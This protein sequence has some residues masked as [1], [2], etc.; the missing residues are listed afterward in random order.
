MYKRQPCDSVLGSVGYIPDPLVKEGK[1]VSLVGDCKQ[2]G[3]LRT[4]IWGAYKVAMK[5]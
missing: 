1:N 2:V 5:L 3:N 4:V